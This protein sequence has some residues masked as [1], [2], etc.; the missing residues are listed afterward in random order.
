MDDLTKVVVNC[1]KREG[2]ICRIL[3][4]VGPEIVTIKDIL[5]NFRSWLGLD[6]A[7][8]IK[9]PLTFIRIAAKLG[10]FFSIGPLNSTSYNMLLQPN[11]AD[12]KDF[13]N[14]TSVV[15]RS[16][17]Q[18]LATEPLTVQSLWHARL[19]LLKLL[20]KI[21]LGLF[22]IMT[23]VITGVFTS[24]RGLKIIIELGFSEQIAQV[25][26]YSSCLADI[27]LGTLMIIKPRIIGV[28]ILQI[29]LMLAYTFFL[30]LL[31]PDLWLEPLGSLT[32]NI[33]IILLTLV[34]LAI[35]KD[36]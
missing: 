13:I 35:E 17:E 8:L 12:K 4:I 26:L 36:K 1:T 25:M 23:G 9:I 6:P 10:D 34:L 16:F 15:P 27:I 22:W 11:I 29:L 32:K 21:I 14:F 2:K 3:K 5:I 33:P 18:G 28:C 31:K 24:E 20:L 30:T 7:K 19:F